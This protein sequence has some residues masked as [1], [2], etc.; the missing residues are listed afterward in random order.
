MLNWC[1]SNLKIEIH[2]I[3]FG[4]L[5]A[6]TTDWQTGHKA[7]SSK[8]RIVI[9]QYLFKAWLFLQ[10]LTSLDFLCSQQ[11]NKIRYETKNDQTCQPREGFACG[12]TGRLASACL[13]VSLYSMWVKN[14]KGLAR[15]TP[16]LILDLGWLWLVNRSFSVT[17]NYKLAPCE[18]NAEG[19][20]RGRWTVQPQ[21]N[22]SRL[23]K[24][25]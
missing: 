6:T 15:Y 14:R 17:K 1:A 24:I 5:K 7:K 22:I 18:W 12:W 10:T 23:T 16:P 19:T 21:D 4:L 13:Y 8:L 11:K 25:Y 3:P 2:Y 20:N 9:V